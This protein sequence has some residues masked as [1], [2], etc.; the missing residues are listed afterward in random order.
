ME[1]SIILQSV[2][3]YHIRAWWCETLR[4]WNTFLAVYIVTIIG[5][6]SGRFQWSS[7]RCAS[8]TLVLGGVSPPHTC[9]LG[10]AQSQLYRFCIDAALTTH[11]TLA[12]LWLLGLQSLLPLC[13]ADPKADDSVKLIILFR[14]LKQ[15]PW[16]SLHLLLTTFSERVFVKCWQRGKHMAPFIC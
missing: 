3:V 16:A 4:T 15:F 10:T 13:R 11:C 7:L 12:T 6:C 9:F 5:W 2:D 14:L 1:C 8:W